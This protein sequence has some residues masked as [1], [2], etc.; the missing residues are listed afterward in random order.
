M[1]DA[2][3]TLDP[4]WVDDGPSILSRLRPRM[5]LDEIKEK[6]EA[7]SLHVVEE[8]RDGNNTGWRLR[9]N[10]NALL[11]L[12]DTGKVVV[13]GKNPGPVRQA[14]ELDAEPK[15]AVSYGATS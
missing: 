6:L 3:D 12:Y 10:C 8:A 1:A 15:A 14:L 13:Q 5:T 4:P 7:A 2:L 9:V 11:N